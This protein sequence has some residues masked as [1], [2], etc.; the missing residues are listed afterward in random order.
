[1]PC[2][3]RFFALRFCEDPHHQPLFYVASF[4][5]IFAT[6]VDSTME[7][8][9]GDRTILDR[10]VDARRASVA[11]RKRVLPDVALKMAVQKAEPRRDFAAALTRDRRNAHRRPRHHQPDAPHA[12][13]QLTSKQWISFRLSLYSGPRRN[14]VCTAA[15]HSSQY[16]ASGE[17]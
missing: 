5:S 4:G 14:T 15:P 1:M 10:I 8:M 13:R 3:S 11:H 17:T 2:L 9:S 16:F 7:T 6:I 12:H